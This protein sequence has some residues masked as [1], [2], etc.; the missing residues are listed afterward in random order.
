MAD[1]RAAFESAGH[2]AVATYIQSG[3]VL[4][5][6]DAPRRSLENDVE[7]MLDRR[8]GTPAY[9]QMTIRSWSTVT[10]LQALLADR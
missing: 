3:N 10:K 8:V 2:R 5:E 1:L 6:T 9:Q 7:A 4:F